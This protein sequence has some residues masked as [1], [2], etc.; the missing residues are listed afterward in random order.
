MAEFIEF[1]QVSIIFN[2]TKNSTWTRFQILN[3]SDQPN[4]LS[5]VKCV[6]DNVIQIFLKIYFN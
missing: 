3:F 5:K 6:F 2:S 1:N 4:K